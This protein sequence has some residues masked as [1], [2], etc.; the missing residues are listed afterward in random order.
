MELHRR[1]DQSLSQ[2]KGQKRKLDQEH[3]DERQIS[4]VPPT[5]DERAALLSDVA[6]QVSILESTFTWNEAD[7]S[8]AKRAT[9]A[10]ADLAKNEEVVNVIVEGDAVPALVKHLQAPPMSD[11]VQKPLPFE[12][13]VEKGSAFALGLLAVKVGL[14]KYSL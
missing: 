4:A 2:R 10:L 11:R 13:E 12:H 7:R 9:H 3:H 6:E 1:Q 14:A 5:A 8:A